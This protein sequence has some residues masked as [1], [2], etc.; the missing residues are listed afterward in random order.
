MRLAIIIFLSVMITSCKQTAMSPSDYITWC[1]SEKSG[2]SVR[3]TFDN[4]ALQL[5]YTPL[6][7][8]KA[9]K[10]V[11]GDSAL[12]IPTSI[13]SS[14]FQF[15]LTLKSRVAE[16][17]LLKLD[18]DQ[19]GY[20]E[21]INYFL[22]GAEN[23]FLL[24]VGEHEYPCTLCHFEPNY[25]LAPQN[26][27][28]LTF[29]TSIRYNSEDIKLLFNDQVFGNGLIEIPIKGADVNTANNITIN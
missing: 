21:R 7:Y 23:D 17:N 8:I 18:T 15:T 24:V 27:L 29:S 4:I 1:K 6:Q 25:G 26:T 2:I 19:N 13:D 5:Q 28:L 16:K 12:D 22:Q 14:L 10:L 11:K 9:L 3:R 20:F